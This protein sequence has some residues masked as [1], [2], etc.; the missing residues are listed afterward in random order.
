MN[1]Q[2]K[3]AVLILAGALFTFAWAGVD[4]PSRASAVPPV[5]IQPKVALLTHD[6]PAGTGGGAHPGGVW[7]TRDL[8]TEVF[9]PANI[10]TFVGNQF[11]L[12][13]G[14]YLI[15]ANQTIFGDVGNP[16]GFKGRLRNVTD[17]VTVAVS[18]SVRVHEEVNESATVVC[19]IPRTLLT[20]AGQTTF[21]LQFFAESPDAINWGLGYP[22]PGSVEVERYASVFVEKLN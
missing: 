6:L 18:L 5:V 1:T 12:K 11:T 22:L 16:M 9:D 15:E 7:T 20:L 8:N 19:P 10:V 17:D 21:E 14:T 3:L 2:M 13:A 4:S